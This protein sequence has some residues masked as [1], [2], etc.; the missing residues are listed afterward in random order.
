MSVPSQII[1]SQLTPPAQRTGVL[2]RERVR[3]LLA[4]SL[5]HSL[6]LLIAGT[7]YGKT[8]SLLSFIHALDVP[9]FWFSVRGAQRDPRLFL[10]YLVSAFNQHGHTLGQ[11]ALRLLND[12]EVDETEALVALVNSLTGQLEGPAVLVLD[13]FQAVQGSAEVVRLTGWLVDHLPEQLHVIISSRSLPE[14]P[15]LNQ[16]RLKGAVLELGWEAL[17]FSPDETADLFRGTYHLELAEED[18]ARL[19]S[20]TEGWAIVLQ[21]VWQSIRSHPQA[22]LRRVLPEGESASLQNLFAYLAEEVLDKLAPSHR[23]FL[24]KT[25]VLSFLD[26]ETCDFL[27]DR[28][29]SLDVLTESYKAGLFLDQLRPGIFRYHHIFREFLLDRLDETP[30]VAREVQR[31]A[32]SYFMAHQDWDSAIAHLL[33]AGDYAQIGHILEDIGER[34]IQSG[35]YQSLSFWLSSMPEEFRANYPYGNYL[36]GQVARFNNHFDQA[37]EYYRTAQRLYQQRGNSWGLS[38]SLRGQAQVYLDTIRP[39]NAT[40]LLNRALTLLD[41]TESPVEVASLLTQ[42]AENQV[43]SGETYQAALN[44][45]RSREISS[46]GNADSDFIQARLLLRTGRLDEGIA[47]LEKLEPTGSAEAIPRPQRFHREA[48]LLMSLF[49]SFKGEAEKSVFYAHKGLELAENLQSSMV[50]SVGG[51]RLGHALQLLPVSRL[52]PASAARIREAYEQAIREV[53]IVRI[54]VEPLWGICRLL[55]YNGQTAECLAVGR[56]AL[57]IAGS[58]GDEWI[59]MLVR[60]SLGASLTMAGQLEEANMHLTVAES[61]A[62]RV[63]DSHSRCAALLWLAL[64]ADRQGFPSS[65][66]V[67]LDQ[68]LSLMRDH[69]YDFLVTRRAMLGADDPAVFL[70]LLL[71]AREDKIQPELISQLLQ[72][73]HL[74]DCVYHP[75]YTLTLRTLGPFEARLGQRLVPPEAWKREKARQ[76]LMILAG[77]RPKVLSREQASVLLWPD[78]DNATS[79]NNFKVVVSALNQALEPA[80]P[81]GSGP[82][83]VLRRQD[84]VQLNPD[85]EIL[86]DHEIFEEQILSARLEDK[87][88]AMGLY[89]GRLF[90]G[91]PAQEWFMAEAQYLHRL[92]LE[93]SALVIEAALAAG[94]LEEALTLTNRLLQIDP[95]FEAG[96][97]LQMRTYHAR[98]NMPMVYQVYRQAREM[99]ARMYGPGEIPRELQQLF[100]R[101]TQ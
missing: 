60:I 50:R 59:S 30:E 70:P 83:F 66:M 7:G 57:S 36:M 14:F 37:L 58:A 82:L 41:P 1:L 68:A 10:S 93:N 2:E 61:V 100:Q 35:R 8:T 96:Y 99:A 9:V 32:A 44:L 74:Q 4:G 18:L 26:S 11:D 62:A 48:S 73:L 49:Y 55:G 17:T 65:R 40:Q 71:Q 86:V 6:T 16:W 53:D 88:S 78:A 22:G 3:A 51:M 19:Q 33:S 67:F 85:I 5:A 24:L 76:L 31:K 42:I 98:G 46:G 72:P 15:G 45:Q 91:E 69:H 64:V 20:R 13:D 75:G 87:Q 94:R 77:S 21:A 95:E 27:L 25:A 63:G 38:R 29:D 23:D 92:Y 97:L 84:Q 101:L 80:R 12:A 89:R 81:A 34:L 54:H 28:G 47:L 56:E 52:D 43:N 90:E 39:I 79:I